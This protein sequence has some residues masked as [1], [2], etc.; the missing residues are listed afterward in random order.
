M[1]MFYSDELKSK[2]LILKSNMLSPFKPVSSTL[3]TGHRHWS[4]EPPQRLLCAL[5]ILF[6]SC[7][8]NRVIISVEW[9]ILSCSGLWRNDPIFLTSCLPCSATMECWKTSSKW[10]MMVVSKL[11]VRKKKKAQVCFTNLYSLGEWF[12]AGHQ[13]AGISLVSVEYRES[14]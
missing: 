12:L 8:P 11:H 3:A 6:G 2:C 5:D 7:C 9:S 13:H 1:D 4:A 10:W 14:I